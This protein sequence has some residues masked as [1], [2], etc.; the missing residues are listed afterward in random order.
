M[1]TV[2]PASH[3]LDLLPSLNKLPSWIAR[4][5][6]LGNRL[7]AEGDDLARKNYEEGLAS[8]SFSFAGDNN[9]NI[10]VRKVDRPAGVH[11]DNRS[12]EGEREAF[13]ARSWVVSWDYV[14]RQS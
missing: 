10:N 2:R 8:V 1:T 4:W 14:V 13:W 11:Q 12:Y 6:K 5:K 3:I 7:F 9:V